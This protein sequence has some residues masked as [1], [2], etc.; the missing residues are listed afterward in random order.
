MVRSEKERRRQMEEDM[1]RPYLPGLTYGEFLD[2]TPHQQSRACQKFTQVVTSYLGYWKTCNLSACRRA[3]AC[4][5]FLSEAQYR[6]DR[7][8][9]SFPPCVGL[10]GVNQQHV[11]EN[12]ERAFGLEPEEDDT[13][14]YAGRLDDDGTEG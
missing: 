1:Q 2:L 14:K 5:G 9:T 6:T 8:L 12:F 7:Y 11:L 10:G 3:K 4:R 13:P